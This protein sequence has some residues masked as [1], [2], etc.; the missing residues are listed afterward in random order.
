MYADYTFYTN[1]FLGSL[2]PQTDYEKSANKASIYMDYYTRNK[3]KNAYSDSK[4]PDS[5]MNAIKLCCCE[6]AEQYFIIERAKQQTAENGG[7]IQ[8]ESVGSY[9][10]TFRSGADTIAYMSSKLPE[11][12]KLYLGN[13]GFLYRGGKNVCSSCCNSI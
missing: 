1:T 6:L 10:R 3:V 5:T 13:L 4:T 7:E 8:S 2:I 9:S 12:V 11:I